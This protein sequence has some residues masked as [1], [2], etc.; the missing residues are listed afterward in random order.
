VSQKYTDAQLIAL[1]HAP[2][3]KMTNGG[4]TPV[5]LNEDDLAALTGYV[6]QLH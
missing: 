3:A 4:M 2:D 6:R 1:L 5:D